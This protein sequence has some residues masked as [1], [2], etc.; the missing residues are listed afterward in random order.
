MSR[1]LPEELSVHGKQGRIQYLQDARKVD[2]RIFGVRMVAVDRKRAQRQQQ[3]ASYGF[4][5]RQV[6]FEKT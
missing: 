1:V 6:F 3:K 4:E 2:F 5:V